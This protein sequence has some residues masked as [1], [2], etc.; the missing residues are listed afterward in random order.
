MRPD[1]Y[2]QNKK[3]V[4]DWTDKTKF[5]IQ[6]VMLKIHVRHGIVVHK[7]H[8]IISF[9]QGKWLEKYLNFNTQKQNQAVNDFEKHLYKLLNNAFY[10]KTI[11]Y[12]RNR[13]E[14]DIIRNYDR[15][16]SIKQQSKIILNEIH[17]FHTI[18]DSYTF[19]QNEVLMDQPKYLGFVVIKLIKIMMYETYYD[20]MQPSFGQENLQLHYRD[21]DSFVLIIRN[22][23]INNE[24][25]NLEDPFEFCNQGVNH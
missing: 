7:V 25:K 18:Y 15:D 22:Q 11:E 24:L 1:T 14:V 16:K 5:L 3:T 13:K 4:S 9:K 17:K 2:T 23:N 6:Y 12:V 21:C 20:N 8:Q 19:K 10:G